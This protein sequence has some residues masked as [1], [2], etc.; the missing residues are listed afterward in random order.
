MQSVS[1][2]DDLSPFIGVVVDG[3]YNQGCAALRCSPDREIVISF[4]GHDIAKYFEVFAIRVDLQARTAREWFP[5][6]PPLIIARASPL[7]RVEWL[8]P[9]EDKGQFLGSGPHSVHCVGRGPAPQPADHAARVLAG[10]W[11]CDSEGRGIVLSASAFPYQAEVEFE[12]FAASRRLE[13]F[14]PIA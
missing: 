7:W 2:R 14:E 13:D 3:Y 12:S 1:A 5:L 10:V 9:T 11:L 4:E 8:E 6:S